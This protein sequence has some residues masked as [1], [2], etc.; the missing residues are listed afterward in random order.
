M[1]GNL[2]YVHVAWIPANP[3]YAL[4]AG[5]TGFETLVYNDER[6]GT[7]TSMT[8]IVGIL[9]QVRFKLSQIHGFTKQIALKY[10]TTVFNKIIPLY[11][12]F[13]PFGDDG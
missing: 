7:G 10:R 6:S 1:D 4:P 9:K 12:I 5:M 13:H 3:R 8:P 11:V 2:K